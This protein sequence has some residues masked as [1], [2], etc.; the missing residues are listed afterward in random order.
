MAQQ[1][2]LPSQINANNT[3]NGQILISNGSAV[4]FHAI[5]ANTTHVFTSSGI[6]Q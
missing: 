1:Q 6:L 2:I 3:A 5:Y 4:A